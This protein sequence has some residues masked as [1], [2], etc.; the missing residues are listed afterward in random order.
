MGG[1]E[2]GGLDDEI[3]GRPRPRRSPSRTLASRS[4]RHH[5]GLC[6]AHLKGKRRCRRTSFRRPQHPRC[7]CWRHLSVGEILDREGLG[8]VEFSMP[9]ARA[10]GAR[11]GRQ[12]DNKACSHV[13]LQP[14]FKIRSAMSNRPLCHA[15]QV[16]PIKISSLSIVFVLALSV[17][18]I[19]SWVALIHSLHTSRRQSSP[20]RSLSRDGDKD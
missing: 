6:L 1:L 13:C 20:P 4:P 16:M 3:G 12:L 17:T 5:G 11:E 15:D 18:K 14:T 19:S 9:E 2:V 8:V 10:T 7:R